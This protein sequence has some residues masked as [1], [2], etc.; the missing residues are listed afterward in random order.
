MNPLLIYIAWV[1]AWQALWE[2]QG[3]KHSVRS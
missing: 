3:G 2:L 1:A